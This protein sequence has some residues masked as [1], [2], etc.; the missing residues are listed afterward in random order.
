MCWNLMKLHVW[1][2]LENVWVY[3][4]K[5][6]SMLLKFSCVIVLENMGLWWK[7][8]EYVA[9]IFM[10]KLCWKMWDYDE[11]LMSM[12]LKFYV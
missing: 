8:G 11:I 2:V 4:E 10:Y 7:I 1:S 5:L 6:M 12:L 3:D 9:E